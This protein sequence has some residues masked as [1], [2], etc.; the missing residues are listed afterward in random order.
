MGV[1]LRRCFLMSVALAICHSSP[2]FTQQN[3]LEM[4][5]GGLNAYN[6]SVNQCP[7]APVV[8]ETLQKVDEHFSIAEPFFWERAKRKSTGL[9]QLMLN[10]MTASGGGDRDPCVGYAVMLSPSLVLASMMFNPKPELMAEIERLENLPKNSPPSSNS[11][12]NLGEALQSMQPHDSDDS[13][14]IPPDGEFE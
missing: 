14:Y 7:Y 6:A 10:V 11:E 3:S 1:N 12:F 9:S 13:D 5:A 2:A 4:F 8:G